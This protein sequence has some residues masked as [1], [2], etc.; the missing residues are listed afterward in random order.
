[1]KK[2]IL[3]CFL[4]LGWLAGCTAERPQSGMAAEEG[5]IR[6]FLSQEAPQTKSNLEDLPS[7]DD[8]EVEIYNAK[9]IR[10]YR[11]TYANAK[12]ATI[13]LNAGEFRL[14]AHHGDTLGAGFNKPYFLADQAFTVHGFV[15]NGGQP[16]QVEATARLANVRM[17]VEQG[18]NLRTSY[19]DAYVVVRHSRYAQKQVKFV[20]N[21]GRYGYMPGGDLYLEVYAQ[22]FNND[23]KYYKSEAVEYLPNDNVTFNVDAAG[24]D[25]ELTVNISVDRSVET[26][27]VVEHIGEK[28]LP[29]PAPYFVFNGDKESPFAYSCNA[30]FTKTVNDAILTLSAGA[31]TSI[32]SVTLH[33][34]S[35]FVT[36]PDVDLVTVDGTAKQALTDAGLDWMAGSTSNL[37]YV[38][39]SGLVNRMMESG[40]AGSASF[41]LRFTDGVGQTVEG[42]LAL[43]VKPFCATV[44][45]PEGNIWAWKMTGITATVAD[46]T[47]IP[48]DASLG[49]QWSTDGNTWSTEKAVVSKNGNTLRFGDITGL[50]PATAY[51]F[52]VVPMHQ[53]ERASVTAGTFTTEAALQVGNG[54]FEDFTQQTYT[55]PV[56][57]SWMPLVD[58]FDVTW[59]QLYKKASDAWWGVNSM[60][61]I[62]ADEVPTGPQ[63]CKTYPTVAMISSNIPSGKRAVMIAT[64]YTST[65]AVSTPIPTLG[66]GTHHNSYGEIFLGTANDQSQEK[67]AKNNPEGHAFTSR[68]SALTFKH[69]FTPKDGTPFY[70]EVSV[71]D[72]SGNVIGS[73]VKNDTSSE[74]SGWTLCTVP[75]TYTVTNKKASTLRISLRSS[76]E[77]NEGWKKTTVETASGEHTIFLGNALYVDDVELLYE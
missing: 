57:A 22:L 16:D 53:T 76:K 61:T 27:D 51:R 35:A 71:R 40:A 18:N 44:N 30:G 12:D 64:I 77:G 19:K 74:V 23:W 6:L 14:V 47:E 68:P 17:K 2:C 28:A 48:A 24:R 5:A 54:G 58:D 69:R 59:W 21:E 25:G 66:A 60:Q 31:S 9:P 42:S 1:M 56:K 29:A 32:S 8:F 11:D 26:I 45:I 36:L 38:D 13:K 15:E 10:L 4:L 67:W 20:K 39:F 63:G 72:A 49:L 55:T 43:D 52:R 65:H 73:G 50:A 7:V 46:V 33:T 70:A 37:G 75:I 62:E 3:P 41:T 34:E